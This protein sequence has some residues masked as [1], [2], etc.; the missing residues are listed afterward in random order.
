MGLG[1]YRRMALDQLRG[2][3][4]PLDVVVDVQNGMPFCSPLVT[5]DPV[6]NLV[7]HVHR[8]V[9][10][11]VLPRVLARLGG[12]RGAPRLSGGPR[13]VAVPAAPRLEL[14]GLGV[15]PGRV[16][17]VHNGTDLRPQ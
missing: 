3:F 14:A 11:I 15:D 5:R 8:E 2:R 16:T 10:P 6:V 17:V 13:Y 9:W 4:G 7:H 1:L 12:A